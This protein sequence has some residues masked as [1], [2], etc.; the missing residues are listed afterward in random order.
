MA[1][2]LQSLVIHCTAT[3][4]GREVSSGDI[5]R[6]HTDPQPAGR[7]WKQV[8]YTDMVHLDGRVERLVDN[9]ED[10]QVDN[11]EITNGAAGYNSISRHIVYVGGV[12][13]NNVNKARDTRTDAQKKAL[14]DYVKDFHKRFP[15]V[16]IVGHNE[17]AAKACPSF[18]V[19]KWLKELKIDEA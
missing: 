16:K 5:R 9:N 12:E 8:G 10:N 19:Q 1:K 14:E 15:N 13:K 4:E 6:W 18:D 3:P 17:L 2:Q 11:W 7:G